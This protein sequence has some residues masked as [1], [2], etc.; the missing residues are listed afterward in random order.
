MIQLIRRFFDDV[1]WLAS[2]SVFSESPE[3]REIVVTL[4]PED[5][6]LLANYRRRRPSVKK[7]AAREKEI[8]L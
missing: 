2:S 5:R 1:H 4:S 6:A 7:E 8:S 3:P